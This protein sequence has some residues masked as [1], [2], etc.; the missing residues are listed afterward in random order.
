MDEKKVE[1]LELEVKKYASEDG[2]EIIEAI[3]KLADVDVKI[4]NAMDEIERIP[5]GL[6]EVHDQLADKINGLVKKVCEENESKEPTGDSDA[7]G[8]HEEPESKVSEEKPNKVHTIN[9]VVTRMPPV[10]VPRIP[11]ALMALMDFLNS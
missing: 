11:W 1:A 8:K 7:K 6:P 10:V 4:K 5:E 9:V 3:R 2:D